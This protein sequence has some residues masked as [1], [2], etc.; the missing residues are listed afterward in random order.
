MT[1]LRNRKTG[2]ADCLK[3][4]RAR[5]VT[6]ALLIMTGATQAAEF[7]DRVQSARAI[8]TKALRDNAKSG[9]DNIGFMIGLFAMVLGLVVML[10]G[11]W[12]VA[13]ASRSEGRKAAGPGW[14]MVVVG[15]ALGAGVPLFM[16][17]VG[18]F[19]GAAG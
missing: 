2:L 17:V 7:T 3:D 19:S 5:L 15:G 18:A 6:T 11:L 10:W 8:D 9:A 12:W 16:W 1:V 13:S 4:A 14:V